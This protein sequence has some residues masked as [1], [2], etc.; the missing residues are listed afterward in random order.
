[1]TP[2][3][4]LVDDVPSVRAMLVDAMKRE[5]YTVVTA[6]SAEEALQILERETVDVIISDESMPGMSGSELL[7]IV[8][9]KYPDTVRMMLTGHATLEST[10]KAI[11][12]G[13]IYRYLLKPCNILDLR[14][15][16]RQALE[17]RRL[18]LENRRLSA[19]VRVQADSLANLE[20]V[21]PGITAVKRDA[22][23]AVVID[24]DE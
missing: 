19:M 22:D 5:P 11:N 12:E 7:A 9:R 8:R 17:R 23:G 14:A 13:E 16:V 2:K 21:C 15:T 24:L 3:V 6:R 4:M 10:L 1:M 18:I 20:D